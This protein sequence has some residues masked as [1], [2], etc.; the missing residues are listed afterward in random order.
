MLARGR[1]TLP[2]RSLRA[3]RGPPT[4]TQD[5]GWNPKWNTTFDVP[6]EW[7]ELAFVRFVV[8]HLD[9]SRA[10]LLGLYTVPFEAIGQGYRH[11]P[12]FD[13]TMN[14]IPYASVHV[15]ISLSP[16]AS[17]TVAPG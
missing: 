11:L 7:P 15:Y 4:P 14:R 6:I 2:G 3:C 5:N 12:L 16:G 17:N 8:Q 10:S 9:G 1:L 13:A